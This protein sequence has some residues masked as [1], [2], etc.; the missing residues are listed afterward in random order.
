MAGSPGNKALYET[1]REM[2]TP[3][4]PKGP[5]PGCLSQGLGQR[6]GVLLSWSVRQIA[7][8]PALA[9][10]AVNSKPRPGW[11][12]YSTAWRCA[13]GRAGGE[14]GERQL[15]DP[16]GFPGAARREAEGGPGTG[17]SARERVPGA[18]GGGAGENQ[19]L[20]LRAAQQESRGGA[21]APDRITIKGRGVPAQL[22]AS[23][24]LQGRSRPCLDSACSAA[25]KAAPVRGF[26]AQPEVAS[27]GSGGTAFRN[28]DAPPR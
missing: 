25:S 22:P 11:G 13:W 4:L 17:R 3:A 23:T 24:P 1:A 14:R 12:P 18:K 27:E 5:A 15:R 19:P 6:S 2:V 16:R 28:F 8:G 7:T 26:H 21:A 10:L 20:L 9:A